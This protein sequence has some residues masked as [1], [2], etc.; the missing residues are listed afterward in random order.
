MDEVQRWILS[1][2]KPEERP[3]TRALKAIYFNKVINQI[4]QANWTQIP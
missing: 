1:L 2:L 4:L 3:T